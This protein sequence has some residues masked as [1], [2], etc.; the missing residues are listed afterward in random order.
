MPEDL[1]DQVVPKYRMLEL[2]KLLSSHFV[3]TL[4]VI[5][6]GGFPLSAR[7]VICCGV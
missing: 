7:S 1:G 6:Q 2:D 5:C 3:F 4:A